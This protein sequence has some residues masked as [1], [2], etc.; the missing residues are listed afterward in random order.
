MFGKLGLEV[1]S[2]RKPIEVA[3]P[4]INAPTSELT[5]KLKVKKLSVGGWYCPDPTTVPEIW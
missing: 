2:T 5:S 1:P 3:P 4:A